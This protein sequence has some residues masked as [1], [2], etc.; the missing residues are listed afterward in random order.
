MRFDSHR[1][2]KTKLF[3]FAT[4]T[5]WLATIVLSPLYIGDLYGTSLHFQSVW[6]GCFFWIVLA[7]TT[8]GTWCCYLYLKATSMSDKSGMFWV[9]FGASLGLLG[10]FVLWIFV[11]GYVDYYFETLLSGKDCIHQAVESIEIHKNKNLVMYW[12]I[13]PALSPC[14]LI[15]AVQE[16][17]PF[18]LVIEK[19][20]HHKKSSTDCTLSVEE[21]TA[22][23]KYDS[24]TFTFP[25]DRE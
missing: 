1:P 5:L 18:G 25:L 11:V 4:L 19:N 10:I 2:S 21:N 23:L 6:L 24:K 12:C 15:L 20:L 14:I 3:F 22:T 13:E 9:K 8:C 16:Q 7:A 17:L